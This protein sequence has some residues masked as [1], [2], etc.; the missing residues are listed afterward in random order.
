M[1]LA[2]NVSL[3]YLY[4]NGMQ[5]IDA[6]YYSK[7]MTS[8]ELSSLLTGHTCGQNTIICVGGGK[9]QERTT[10]PDETWIDLIS[11]GDCDSISKRTKLNEA[12]LVNGA[13]WYFTPGY[14][15]GFAANSI[16]S[17]DA[18]AKF[19]VLNMARDESRLSWKLDGTNVGGRL[20]KLK[21]EN[22]N[23]YKYIFVNDK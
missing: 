15:F 6:R 17:Q 19:D 16:I 13:Y 2:K 3:G 12:R 11:C 14:S 8:D 4:R 22:S 21:I 23:Y 5:K 1:S 9:A 18:Y 7:K 10:T 20:G